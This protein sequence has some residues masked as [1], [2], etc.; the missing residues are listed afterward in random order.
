MIGTQAP[1]PSGF[2]AVP[3][4]LTYTGIPTQMDIN[5]KHILV[6]DKSTVYVFERGVA[7]LLPSEF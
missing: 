3:A 2:Y 6:Q 1:L 4:Q 7:D 5:N